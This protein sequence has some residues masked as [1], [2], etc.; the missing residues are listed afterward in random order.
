MPVISDPA[1]QLHT[2]CAVI[3]GYTPPKANDKG[4]AAL[5]SILD[6]EANSSEYFMALGAIA[7]RFHQLQELAEAELDE[8]YRSLLLSTLRSLQTSVSAQSQMNHWLPVRDQIFSPANMQTLLMASGIIRQHVVISVPTAEERK[9]AI[10]SIEEA[11]RALEQYHGSLSRSLLSALTSTKRI[12]TRFDIYGTD[13]LTEE[14]LKAF[15]LKAASEKERG[16][17]K[18]QDAWARAWGVLVMVASTLVVGDA[19]L[20]AVENHYSRAQWVLSHFAS[21]QKQLPPPREGHANE[22][23]VDGRKD[24]EDSAA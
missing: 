23:V 11:M 16:T 6:V 18:E 22:T 15:S 19:A 13:A 7:S 20:T 9:N 5:A 2:L 12:L 17:A 14:L 4:Q 10:E 3:A 21:E 1:A 8:P 24:E